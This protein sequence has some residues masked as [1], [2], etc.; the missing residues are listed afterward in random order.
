[1]SDLRPVYLNFN[2]RWRTTWMRVIATVLPFCLIGYWNPLAML[3]LLAFIITL[4]FGLIDYR[5]IEMVTHDGKPR[6]RDIDF[7]GI[8]NGRLIVQVPSGRIL[9]PL[10]NL[11]REQG[12]KILYVLDSL[13]STETRRATR[14]ALAKHLGGV[15]DN[16]VEEPRDS[17]ALERKFWIAWTIAAICLIAAIYRRIIS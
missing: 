12:K 14:E 17:G 5:R 2:S 9:L 16:P 11:D 10:E 6:A 15:I 1:M 13:E 3:V 7:K 4:V 8:E